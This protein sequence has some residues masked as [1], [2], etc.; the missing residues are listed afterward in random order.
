M[1]NTMAITPKPRRESNEK[2]VKELIN[3]GGS[4]TRG[5]GERILKNLQVR[6]YSDVIEE[7]DRHL[8][9]FPGKVSRHSWIVEAI[10]DKL[11]KERN[12]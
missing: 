3:K 11:E 4:S 5:G 1:E 12:S 8:E 6:L 2:K 10:H 9:K 7:I